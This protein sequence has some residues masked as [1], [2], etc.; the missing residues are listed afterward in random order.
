MEDVMGKSDNSDANPAEETKV[1]DDADARG[2]N[3]EDAIKSLW[4][5]AECVNAGF[6]SL[7]EYIVRNRRHFNERPLGEQFNHEFLDCPN[8]N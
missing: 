8:N 5:K 6:V 2:T 3:L 7:K 4:D 1:V